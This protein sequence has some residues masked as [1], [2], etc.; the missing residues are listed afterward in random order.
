MTKIVK[1]KQK[2]DLK[3]FRNETVGQQKEKKREMKE[4]RCELEKL[5]QKKKRQN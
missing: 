3:H 1:L 5:F 4:I 2:Q